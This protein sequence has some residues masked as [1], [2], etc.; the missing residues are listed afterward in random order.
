MID[1]FVPENTNPNSVNI[2]LGRQFMTLDERELDLQKS[3]CYFTH[4]IPDGFS[5][6]LKKGN[7]YL[8]HTMESIGSNRYVPIIDGRSTIGRYGVAVHITAGVG[9]TGFFGQFTLELEA[10]HRDTI[11]RPGDLIAQVSFET[12][13]GEITLYQGSYANRT[14]PCGPKP[15]K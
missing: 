10:R 14:G 3:P 13:E 6:T 12:V 2:R 11:V 5:L 9:D 8:G 4:V 1:P 15:L 7:V